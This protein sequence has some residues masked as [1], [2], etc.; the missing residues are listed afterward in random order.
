MLIT[1]DLGVVAGMADNVMVMYAGRLVERGT[2]DEIF[3]KSRHP[4][5]AGPAAVA[6]PHRRAT[7]SRCARSAA[8]RRR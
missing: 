8:S 1:H 3:D 7:T 6:A 4:Y 2:V 5:T